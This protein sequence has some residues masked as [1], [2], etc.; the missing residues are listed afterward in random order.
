MAEDTTKA[1]FQVSL[2]DDVS[3]SAESA[4][5]ALATLKEQLDKDSKALADM[6]KAMRQLKQATTAD[7]KAPMESLTKQ[8]AAQKNTI[9]Q[10]Q[11]AYVALGGKF[12]SVKPKANGLRAALA[13]LG[14]EAQQLPGPVGGL[15]ARLSTLVGGMG[16]AQL[17]A[18]ALGAAFLGVA[19]AAAKMTK[20]LFG[21][22][23]AAQDATRNELLHFQALTKMR[24]LLGIAPGNADEMQAAVDRVSASVSIGRDKVAGYAETLYRAGLRGKNLEVALEGTSVKASA[25]GDAAGAGF[26]GFAAT[27]ALSGGAVKRLADDVKNRFGGVVQKQ[28]SSLQVQQLKARENW[29]SLFRGIR[30]EP[31]LDSLKRLRDM[32]NVNTAAGQ[33]LKSLFTTFLQPLFNAADTGLVFMRRFFKQMLIGALEMK[34]AYQEVRNWFARTFGKSQVTQAKDLLDQIDLGRYAVYA[35]ATAFTV[36][37]GKATISAIAAL[38]RFGATLLATV[39]PAVWSAVTATASFAVSILAVTWPFLLAAVAVAAFVAGIAALYDLW[40]EIDWTDLGRNLWKGLVDGLKG[41]WEAVK[42]VFSDLADEAANAFKTALGIASPSKVFAELGIE[43]PKGVQ[44]GIQLG[45]PAAQQAAA[46]V[47]TAPKLGSTTQNVPAPEAGTSAAAAGG[48]GARTITIG[49][50]HIHATSSEP[51][52]LAAAFRRELES[53]LEGVSLEAGAPQLGAT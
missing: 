31:F 39:I 37:A 25:L 48:K 7:V 13:E 45:T 28:M 27:V 4:A 47:V 21:E 12:G 3:A 5:G 38:V 16:T 8:I 20:S 51:K 11:G 41:G 52:T 19:F 15:V 40:N 22:A 2:Q 53:V 30:I 35:L 17:T 26:A 43:I 42:S 32:L 33:A 10:A 14:K 9:A 49:E 34:I 23:L 18:I 1:T 50:L 36:L 44:Q 29:N 46:D 24:N 6:Q